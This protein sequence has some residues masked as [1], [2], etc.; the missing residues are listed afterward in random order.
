MRR[1]LKSG[2]RIAERRVMAAMYQYPPRLSQT[3]LD[4][5]NDLKKRFK[6]CREGEK[7]EIYHR[8]QEILC[9]ASVLERLSMDEIFIMAKNE[10]YYLGHRPVCI[11]SG[12]QEEVFTD[13]TDFRKK[14][15]ILLAIRKKN[16]V[17]LECFKI[18]GQFRH[19]EFI[20][21]KLKLC[22]LEDKEKSDQVILDFNKN[23]VISVKKGKRSVERLGDIL[24]N[25][26]KSA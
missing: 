1:F 15:E 16:F 10:E 21:S 19:N 24:L 7:K 13:C 4:E 9:N 3:E 11:Y 2:S 12:L 20:V 17:Y 23:R 5:L 6:D 26:E 25:L 14:F 22:H 8:M 18:W